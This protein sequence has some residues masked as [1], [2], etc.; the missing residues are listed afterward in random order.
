MDDERFDGVLNA[1]IASREAAPLVS[2]PG[3]RTP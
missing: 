3:E 2:P 1:L